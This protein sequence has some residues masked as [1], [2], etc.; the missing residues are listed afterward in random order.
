MR[1]IVFAALLTLISIGCSEQQLP[2]MT[3]AQQKNYNGCMAGHWSS[4]ADTIWWGP[5][6]WA[7]YES[8]RKDCLAVANSPGEAST[9]EAATAPATTAGGVQPV[10]T[11]TTEAI[12]GAK[13][14]PGESAH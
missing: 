1:R 4:G 9:A 7:W 3:V 8:L 6:G 10:S 13:P 14:A 12:P 2:I 11:S 5:F